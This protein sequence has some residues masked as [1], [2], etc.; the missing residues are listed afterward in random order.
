MLAWK[1][2][3][4][5]KCPDCGTRSGDWGTDNNAF[6][7]ETDRCRGCEKI[8]W[9]QRTWAEE[10]ATNYGLRFRLVRSDT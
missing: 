4:A 7:V 6:Y 2:E 9:E 8:G 1:I 10:G 5:L 3:E